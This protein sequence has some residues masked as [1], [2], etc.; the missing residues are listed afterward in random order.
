MKTLTT[1]ALLIVNLMV[2]S[3]CKS[4]PNKPSGPPGTPRWQHSI[5]G[6]GV[7]WD[8]WQVNPKQLADVI[9]YVGANTTIIE[10]D[11]KK[12]PQFVA[13]WCKPFRDK[14]LTVEIII[15][16]A[17][18]ESARNRP[19]SEYQKYVTELIA[20]LKTPDYI[21]MQFVTEP[22]NRGGDKAKLRDWIKWG[23]S[24]WPGKEV[25]SVRDGW[26]ANDIPADYKEVHWCVDYPNNIHGGNEIVTTDCTPLIN[27]SG[28][29]VYTMSKKFL[30]RKAHFIYYHADWASVKQGKLTQIDYSKLDG[31]KRAIEEAS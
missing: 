9:D 27:V 25:Q 18:T 19:T 4:L 15:V 14:K 7:A 2:F 3:G 5:I 8:W 31:I 26:W 1:S 16:N 13:N 21:L 17:N 12:D 22:G 10:I 28:N 24:K 11:F 6:Y 20:A 29:Q 30:A 23:S